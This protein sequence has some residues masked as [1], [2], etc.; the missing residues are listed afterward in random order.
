VSHMSDEFLSEKSWKFGEKRF[1][2]RKPLT[3][4][5]LYPVK[6]RNGRLP[7]M[8]ILS[9]R[10]ISCHAPPQE[11]NQKHQSCMPENEGLDSVSWL[12]SNQFFGTKSNRC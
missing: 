4:L 6:V 1:P 8:T 9:I 5:K 2:K 11:E 3:L 7:K 12:P 10:W